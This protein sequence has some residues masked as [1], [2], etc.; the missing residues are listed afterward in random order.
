MAET[1]RILVVDDRA[2][3][4]TKEYLEGYSPVPEGDELDIIVLDDFDLAL[5]KID[6]T[7]FDAIV[8]DLKEDSTEL[9]DEDSLR[10]KEV[11]ELIRKSKFTPVVFYTAFPNRVD[12]TETTF[13]KIVE[14]GQWERLVAAIKEVFATKLIQLSRHIENQKREF[15]WDFVEKQWNSVKSE[16]VSE[17]E[18]AHTLARRLSDSLKKSAITF[19]SDKDSESQGVIHPIEM[20]I[21]P[22][23]SFPEYQSGDVI[24]EDEDGTPVHFVLLTPTCDLVPKAKGKKHAEF[25]LRARC[26]TLETEP[27]FTKIKTSLSKGEPVSNSAEKE[28][29]GTIGNN[30]KGQSTRYFFLPSILNLFPELIVDFQQ[31]TSVSLQEYKPRRLATLDSPYSEL[32]VQRMTSFLSRIGVPDLN[33]QLIYER[34]IEL[35]APK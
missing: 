30:R 7:S 4:E 11:F 29:K 8:L 12:A 22:P 24:V 2:G 6:S 3:E 28:L 10:G 17:G 33:S 26:L 25:L 32:L 1:W 20:Y 21:A 5:S 34:V 31:L 15:M 23:P 13:L 18:L 19:F 14:R 35:A 27:E 9:A 16:L